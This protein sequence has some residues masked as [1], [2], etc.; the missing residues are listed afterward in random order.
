MEDCISR[1]AVINAINKEM[2]NDHLSTFTPY[3]R[4]KDAVKKVA[5]RNQCH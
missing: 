4:C 5:E 1:Q 2:N 3:A